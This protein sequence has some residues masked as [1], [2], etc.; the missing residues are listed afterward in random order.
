MAHG[1]FFSDGFKHHDIITFH[2]LVMC[3]KYA[4]YEDFKANYNFIWEIYNEVAK[5]HGIEIPYKWVSVQLKNKNHR[6]STYRRNCFILEPLGPTRL[7]N[8]AFSI[9]SNFNTGAARGAV[10]LDTN[11][12]RMAE[13]YFRVGAA[14]PT[15]PSTPLPRYHQRTNLGIMCEK[16]RAI[17]LVAPNKR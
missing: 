7:V 8:H 12:Y 13:N 17:K 16:F 10:A 4:N 2:D 15:L 5:M 14:A 1:I 9:S 3:P 11:W 6:Y